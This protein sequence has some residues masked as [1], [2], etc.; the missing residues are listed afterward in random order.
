ML[1]EGVGQRGKQ[2]EAI[3]ISMV[4]LID[5]LMVWSGVGR[6][7]WDHSISMIMGRSWEVGLADVSDPNL[8]IKLILVSESS[9]SA[10]FNLSNFFMVLFCLCL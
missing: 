5:I 8:T 9:S 6:R 4:D 10:E 7:G 3:V 1:W 2:N